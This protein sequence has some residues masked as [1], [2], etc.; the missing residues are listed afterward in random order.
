MPGPA[1]ALGARAAGSDSSTR[2]VRRARGSPYGELGIDDIER[3]IIA[4]RHGAGASVDPGFATAEHDDRRGRTRRADITK[5][6]PEELASTG[7]R[8]TPQLQVIRLIT[9]CCITSY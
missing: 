8:E 1:S 9:H 2:R 5:I 6:R 3:K 7:V 4:E